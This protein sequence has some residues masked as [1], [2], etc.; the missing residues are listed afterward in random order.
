MTTFS[1]T[2]LSSG[3]KL[4]A[5][6]AACLAASSTCSFAITFTTA[7][8]AAIKAINLHMPSGTTVSTG[9]PD[10]VDAATKATIR[11]TS[12][13]SAVSDASLVSVAV[14]YAPRYAPD[15]AQTALADI[16]ADTTLS[17]SKRDSE[18]ASIVNSAMKAVL[19]G[20][21]TRFP[22]G[23]TNNSDGAAAV[24]SVAVAAVVNSSFHDLLGIVV[25]NAVKTA[26][27]DG[28]KGTE[29]GVAG[30]VTGAIS[31]T[32]GVSNGN[33]SDGDT[34]DAVVISVITAAAKAAPGR[35]V[36]IATAVGYA[37]AGTYR[38]TTASGQESP[39]DFL[40]TNLAGLVS[41]IEAGLSNKNKA[42]YDSA[43]RNQVTAGI[44]L[45]YTG[46][47]GPG[48]GGTN[49][50]AYN[51]GNGNAVTNVQNL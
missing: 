17:P 30:A 43:I 24:T 32:A 44:A 13:S 20:S 12:V 16:A 49:D 11:D 42:K 14:I 26:A 21:K 28:G 8:K 1:G 51:N 25:T 50:F 34:S 9:T 38:A 10:Q 19:V 39:S 18:A 31:Q 45:A 3:V 37:F 40:S 29:S 2:R 23:V 48:Q 4:W 15:I 5:A 33:I 22:G 47:V 7:Q 27:K 35:V 36:D 46:F 6:A 41:A